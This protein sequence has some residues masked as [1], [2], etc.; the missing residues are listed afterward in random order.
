MAT[1]SRR[2]PCGWTGPLFEGQQTM[3][4]DA[5]VKGGLAQAGLI[6][7]LAVLAADILRP[8]GRLQRDR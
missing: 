2:I 3:K 4:L 8:A 6:V 1:K 7:I 5:K